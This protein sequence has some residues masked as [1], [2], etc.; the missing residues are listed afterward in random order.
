MRRSTYE[1]SASI[2]LHYSD[3]EAAL[4]ASVSGGGAGADRRVEESGDIGAPLPVLGLRGTWAITNTLSVDVSG[5]YFSMTY[6]DIEGNVQNYRAL[7]NW[8]PKS[9]L[10]LGVGYDSFS[11]DVDVDSNRFR[12]RMDWSY[13]G[14]MIFYSASF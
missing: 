5:Q 4:G 1:L 2:G 3:F 9:W 14:P 8:Q 7:L 10:G 13:Q 11:L 12:G 6:G